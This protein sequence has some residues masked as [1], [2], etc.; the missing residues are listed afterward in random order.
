ME[1]YRWSR[2]NIMRRVLRHIDNAA[3]PALFLHNMARLSRD[4]IGPE[5]D[6]YFDHF[7]PVWGYCSLSLLHF[8]HLLYV[9]N[10]LA[11]PLT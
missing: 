2:A 3:I 6:C 10:P 9:T 5:S 8:S 4:I 7:L 11:S 1:W